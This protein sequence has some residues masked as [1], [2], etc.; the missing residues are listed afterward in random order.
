MTQRIPPAVAAEVA[1]L[2]KAESEAVFRSA[3]RAAGGDRAEA[4]N[5]VQEVFEAAALQWA[6]IAAYL[7]DRR[8]AW[9]CR[10]ARNKAI[11]GYRAGKP[12]QLAAD[13]DVSGESPSAERVA[14]TRMQKDRCVKVISQMPEMRRKVA[15]LKFHEEW[16]TCE[17][18]EYLSIAAGT[19]RVHVHGARVML[20]NAV[21]PEVFLTE[22]L[23]EETDVGE[24]EAR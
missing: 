6:T 24:E 5:L 13:P 8:R 7:P 21:G 10:V 4:E 16:K 17:I 12:M 14:L 18:A 1:R 20:E 9:L 19:V 3:L 23:A 15:Y 11:D 2:F 22:D